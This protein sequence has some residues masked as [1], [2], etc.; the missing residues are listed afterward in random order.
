MVYVEKELL[1]GIVNTNIY[2]TRGDSCT[3]E[4]PLYTK[5]ENGERVEYTP[6]QS[7]SFLIQV[8][9]SP[10][11]NSDNVPS[12]IFSGNPVIENNRV[13]WTV[14]SAD[15]TKN[16]RRYYWDFQITTNGVV[17]T[18]YQGWFTILPESSIAS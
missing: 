10:V 14:S 4:L 15:S 6:T 13:R 16:S 18:P 5:N 1:N 7:D 2:L 9:S 17:F 12:I 8:R 11:T 3:F